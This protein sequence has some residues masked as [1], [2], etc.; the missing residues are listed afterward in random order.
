MAEQ[1]G[2]WDYLEEGLSKQEAFERQERE[3]RT[4]ERITRH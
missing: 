2:L 3:R 1:R 4:S